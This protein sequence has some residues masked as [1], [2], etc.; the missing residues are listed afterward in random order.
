MQ[1]VLSEQDSA[2]LKRI[3]IDFNKYSMQFL[4][5]EKIAESSSIFSKLMKLCKT[6]GANHPELT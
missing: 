4:N 2:L 3:I 5:F 6:Y 1:G